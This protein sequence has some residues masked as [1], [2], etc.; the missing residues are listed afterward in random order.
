MKLIDFCIREIGIPFAMDF[1]HAL[2]AR[3]Q[4]SA[5]IFEI[6]TDTGIHG[7]GEGTPREYVTGES[8]GSTVKALEAAAEKLIGWQINP[9]HDAVK[10][11]EGLTSALFDKETYAPSA[12][13]A[14]ELALIDTL[15]KASKKSAARLLGP[16]KTSSICFSGIV[17]DESLDATKEILTLI[18]AFGFN[19]VKIK[20]GNDIDADARKLDLARSV[21]GDTA[22]IRIDANAVWRLPEAVTKIN[23]YDHDFNVHIIEQPLAAE[24]RADYPKLM[25][26]VA[27]DIKI[28]LDESICTLDDARWFIDNQAATGF[29]LKISKHGGLIDT[30]K[31]YHLAC[32]H[33]FDCQLGCHVGETAI[34][35][36]AGHVFA[37]LAD[38]LIAYEGSYGKYL[39]IHD[40]VNDPP[41]F[42][43]QGLFRMDGL[44]AS[45]GFGL[46]I[47]PA[48][49]HKATIRRINIPPI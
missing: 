16:L 9:T 18:K 47:N 33:G 21:L 6:T 23:R 46:S 38:A 43:S 14:L 5:V 7:Y 36:T 41:Q 45:P 22:Q 30:L 3:T 12:K 8:V 44:N 11:I 1:K 15:G 40:V 28:I 20:V 49:V 17:S 2:A 13:C 26:Q 39:L 29:N 32:A 35:T 24:R 25:E 4:T 31:I 10:Q 19:Q 37:G 34:L 27:P 48:L 42:G